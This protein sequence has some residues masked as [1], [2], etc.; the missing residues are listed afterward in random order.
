MP[1]TSR[2]TT[3]G[4]PA[5]TTLANLDRYLSTTGHD[6]DHPW[7]K[8]IAAAIEQSASRSSAEFQPGIGAVHRQ[9]SWLCGI[10]KDTDHGKLAE[11]TMDVCRGIR[12]CLEL[13]NSSELERVHNTDADPRGESPP[14]LD[15]VDTDHLL[16]LA[17][18]AS[19][20]LGDE[21][22]RRI[23]RM[24]EQADRGME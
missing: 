19:K 10:A 16:R 4:S 2:S 14:I 11:L 1:H 23:F 6:A 12:T 22:E 20:L 21:A 18:V 13:V 8:E 7:R 24:N 3:T 15:V 5:L 9:F 17:I